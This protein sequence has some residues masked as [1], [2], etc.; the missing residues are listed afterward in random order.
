M[1]KK[2]FTSGL[3]SVFSAEA[4]YEP[5]IDESPWLVETS[6]T[7]AAV[8]DEPKARPESKAGAKRGAARRPGKSFT[9]DLDSLFA[10]ASVERPR[11]SAP[12]AEEV[13]ARVRNRP[14]RRVS[15]FTGLD[16]LIRDTTDGKALEQ[17][18]RAEAENT[19][20]RKRVTFTYDRDRFARLKSIARAEG[21]YLK[22]IIS[23]LLN[24]Y[25]N[26]HERG[27]EGSDPAADRPDVN[28][29]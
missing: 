15:A 19:A 13:N 25:I 23:G 20:V 28:Y 2:R 8:A 9:S 22:D 21:A 24:D 11:E 1:S 17:Q 27:G 5:N 26:S 4:Q 6:A 29:A 16:G 3:D 10:V 12:A 7:A 14:R 18:A